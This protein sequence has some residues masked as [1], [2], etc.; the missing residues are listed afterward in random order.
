M[1]YDPMGL[2]VQ[3][4]GSE[5]KIGYL[6]DPTS[7]M[8]HF[9][10]MSVAAEYKNGLKSREFGLGTRP[11]EVLW[12]ENSDGLFYL[13]YDG[14][15]SVVAATNSNGHTVAQMAYDAFGKVISQTG[16]AQDVRYGFTGR[17]MDRDIG[18]QYN[19]S[20]YY[21]AGVGRWNRADEWRGELVT[22][23]SLRR[24]V[25][26]HQNPVNAI[27]PSGFGAWS[28]ALD[29]TAYIGAINGARWGVS[30]ML[31][32]LA[33]GTAGWALIWGFLAFMLAAYG[34]MYLICNIGKAMDQDI[35]WVRS[36]EADCEYF[37]SVTTAMSFCG[38]GINRLLL[39]LKNSDVVGLIMDMI[40]M[41]VKK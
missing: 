20:R 14:L 9:N 22:P 27:D 2:R 6:I 19:R 33:A 39:K 23:A 32:A 4:V 3:S 41:A 28:S 24:Y 30:F 31:A 40:E 17:P 15:G 35:Y 36:Q 7:Q 5:G 29:W 13:L 26:V 25:Y 1:T 10:T 37:A 38:T 21:E 8:G 12:E 11:D 16:Q 34:L 18:L